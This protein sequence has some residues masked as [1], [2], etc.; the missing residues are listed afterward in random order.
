M[1]NAPVEFEIRPATRLDLE[2]IALLE[3]RVYPPEE[4]WSF[5]DYIEDHAEPGRF[6]LVAELASE[7]V[8]YAISNAEDPAAPVNVTALTVSPHARGTGLGRAL[9]KALLALHPQRSFSLEVRTDNTTAVSLY[10][11]CG[12][13]VVGV[14]SDFYAPSIDAFEMALPPRHNDASS[15]APPHTN[16]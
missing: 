16:A 1:S 7:L 13:S 14:L 2:A 6:Y 9:L 11:S 4:L 3:A 5:E 10:E 12:F 15:S 8:G